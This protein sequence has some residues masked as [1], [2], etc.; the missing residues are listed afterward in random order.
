M[1]ELRKAIRV[2]LAPGTQGERFIKVE[3][4]CDFEG[5]GRASETWE[6][7]W[8]LELP[9]VPDT[10]YKRKG[11]FHVKFHGKTWGHVKAKALKYLRDQG[12]ICMDCLERSHGLIEYQFHGKPR[13]ACRKCM[14]RRIP[15]D[16]PRSKRVE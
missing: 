14:D 16:S 13:R 6:E 12:E 8:W 9:Q 7:H 3:C 4:Y 15:L 1:D 11:D 5:H 2:C 10:R